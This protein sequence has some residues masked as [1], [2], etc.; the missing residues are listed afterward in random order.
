[1]QYFTRPAALLPPVLG[2]SC[3]PTAGVGACSA[4][5]RRPHGRLPS[6]VRGRVELRGASTWQARRHAR[7]QAWAHAG[8]RPRRPRQRLHHAS[9][10][11]RPAGPHQ[12]CAAL[13][14]ARTLLPPPSFAADPLPWMKRPQSAVYTCDHRRAATGRGKQGEGCTWEPCVPRGRVGVAPL[15]GGRAASCLPARRQPASHLRL[16]CQRL[17]HGLVDVAQAL[18]A[19]AVQE[20]KGAGYPRGGAPAGTQGSSSRR[21]SAVW[22]ATL[23]HPARPGPAGMHLLASQPTMHTHHALAAMAALAAV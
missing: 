16:C 2:P 6:H 7:T 5:T 10:A 23:A 17:P 8:G 20:P 3:Q 9:P 13:P 22:A 18:K 14:L 19:V 12:P 21:R 4:R 11:R 15:G 1:M